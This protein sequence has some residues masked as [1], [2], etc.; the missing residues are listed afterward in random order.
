M[1]RLFCRDDLE[2]EERVFIADD[3]AVVLCRRFWRFAA[4]DVLDAVDVVL[5]DLERVWADL[6]DLEAADAPVPAPALPAT[7]EPPPAA[8]SGSSTAAIAPIWP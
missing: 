8:G 3:K 1:V 5:D 6:F 4:D 7:A 2:I